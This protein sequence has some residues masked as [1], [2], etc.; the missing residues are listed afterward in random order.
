MACSACSQVPKVAT[1]V[2]VHRRSRPTRSQLDWTGPPRHATPRLTASRGR[3]FVSQ[4]TSR[5][6]HTH[7]TRSSMLI[8]PSRP[9]DRFRIPITPGLGVKGKNSRLWAPA[10]SGCRVSAS[11]GE[12]EWR[13]VVL[14]LWPQKIRARD[15][16]SLKRQAEKPS[17]NNC[18][19]H[20]IHKVLYFDGSSWKEPVCDGC[21][22]WVV[23]PGR[24][25]S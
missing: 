22:K 11:H 5:S 8:R 4:M 16:I 21:G 2:N 23:V 9:R 25:I 24:G 17:A 3:R 10:S 12:S 14:G 18:S 6:Y 13:M 1:F 19:Q 7:R 20:S 15:E